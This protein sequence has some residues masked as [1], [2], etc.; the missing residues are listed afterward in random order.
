MGIL[1]PRQGEEQRLPAPVAKYLQP[2]FDALANKTGARLDIGTVPVA[3]TNL[4]GRAPGRAERDKILIDTHVLSLPF[5]KQIRIIAHELMH[6]LQFSVTPGA[7]PDAR[8]A[9]MQ[10]RYAEE[11]RIYG[12]EAQYG[13]QPGSGTSLGS[14]NV[15]D[16][17]LTL[18]GA[19]EF[20]GNT[21]QNQYL[22]SI[23]R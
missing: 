1:Q 10:A 23:G 19:A 14:V 11:A 21:V 13:V 2:A 7:N 15:V 3:V 6:V 5:G 8:D 18:E 9:N 12:G 22:D 4:P 16:P 20:V 17:S